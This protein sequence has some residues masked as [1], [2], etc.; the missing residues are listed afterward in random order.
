MAFPNRQFCWSGL[1]NCSGG[2]AKAT[3]VELSVVV[4]SVCEQSLVLFHLDPGSVR[5]K[6]DDGS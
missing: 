2:N 4:L 1:L 3:F 6:D 5:L